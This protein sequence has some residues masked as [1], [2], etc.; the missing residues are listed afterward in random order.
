MLT[1]VAITISPAPLQGDGHSLVEV[2]A[3]DVILLLMTECQLRLSADGHSRTIERLPWVQS[4]N[5]AGE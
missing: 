5:S 2:L 1:A 3:E 4:L